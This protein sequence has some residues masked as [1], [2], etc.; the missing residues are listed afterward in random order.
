MRYHIVVKKVVYQEY[1]VE[2]SSE[3]EAS[4]YVTAHHRELIP[5]DEYIPELKV[6][7]VEYND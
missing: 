3:E 7:V 2:A 4:K 1:D 5:V 6:N